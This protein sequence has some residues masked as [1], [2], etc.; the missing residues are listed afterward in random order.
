MQVHLIWA[1]ALSVTKNMKQDDFPE[2]ASNY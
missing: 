1:T 2:F